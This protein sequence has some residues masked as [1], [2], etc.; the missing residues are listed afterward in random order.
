M[1]TAIPFPSPGSL[2]NVPHVSGGHHPAE[3][4]TWTRE[5]RVGGIG[6]AVAGT[7]PSSL[8]QAQNTPAHLCAASDAI[9]HHVC[10]CGETA[11]V[12]VFCSQ[13]SR[14]AAEVSPAVPAPPREPGVSGRAPNILPACHS[15]ADGSFRAGGRS[16]SGS[17]LFL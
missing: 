17:A 6:E 16:S 14:K 5:G 12:W 15:A 8:P 13:P 11:C 10:F 3:R 7:R 9:P 1:S 4:H 2:R